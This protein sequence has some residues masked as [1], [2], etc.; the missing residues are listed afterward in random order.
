MTGKLA[1][2]ETHQS[3]RCSVCHL[4]LVYDESKQAFGVAITKPVSVAGCTFVPPDQV[5]F[6]DVVNMGS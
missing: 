4:G 3:R 1:Y 6:Q 2:N 5:Q